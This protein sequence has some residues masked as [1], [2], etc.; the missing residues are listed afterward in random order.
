ML[1][2]KTTLASLNVDKL[3][4]VAADLSNLGNLVDN[5]VVKK[6]VCDKFV[7]KG[8]AID[9]R[10][11]STKTLVTLTRY[12]SHKQGLE[13]KIKD[14]VKKVPNTNGLDK[15]TDYNTKVTEIE[16]KIPS[17]TGLVTTLYKSHRN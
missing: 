11:I 7:I 8:N 2:S 14:G 17:V 15:K 4:T 9:T 12:V 10:I 1:A 13:K 5:D 16:N 6:T 3:K